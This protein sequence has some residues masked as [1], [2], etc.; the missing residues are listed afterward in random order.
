MMRGLS[1]VAAGLGVLLFGGVASAQPAVGGAFGNQGEF[2]ISADRL[3]PVFGYTK[4]SVDTAA[5][6]GPGVQKETTSDDASMLGVFWGGAP[7]FELNAGGVGGGLPFAVPNVFTVPRVGF[8][9]T[10]VPNVTIG[11]DLILFFTLG[12]THSTQTINTNG[13][14]QTTTNNEPTSTVFGVAPRGGYILR[15]SD[16]LALWLRGGFSFYTVNAKLTTTD[17]ANNQTTTTVGYNQLALDLDPQLVITPFPRFGFT[18]GLTGD[19]PL[20]GGHFVSVTTPNASTTVSAGSSLLFIGAT[21]GILGW[22]GG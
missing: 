21:A 3:F 19:I 5:N 18:V 22:F 10:I 17:N 15:L 13:S 2:I 1:A 7:G 11:G 4:A 8:D 20:T 9:Y 12:G 16:L 14:T 6:L